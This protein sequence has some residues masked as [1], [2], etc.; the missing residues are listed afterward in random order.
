[1]TEMKRTVGFFTLGCK[2][3]Q[4]ESEAI[5]ELFEARGYT[6]LPSEDV[7]DVYI[8][9]TCTVTAES[10]RK[11][12][13]II[14]R[15]ITR[16]PDAFIL[17]TG[18]LA[19][20]TPESI[21][22]IPGVDYVCGNADKTGIVDAADRLMTTKEKNCMAD[23]RVLPLD[24]MP[25]EPMKIQKFDRTRAYIK[26]EDGCESH[27]TYCIIPAARG[28]IRSKPPAEVLAEVKSLTEGGCREIV[29]TG[30]ETA[31]YGKD[32]A[33]VTLADLLEEV[34]RIPGIGRIRL[35]SLDPSLMKPP[36]V[37]R[38]S[39]LSS[40]APHFHLSMQSGSD[41][42]LRRMKRKYNSTMALENI[43]ELRRVIPNLMLTT[44]MIVGFPGE[45]EEDFEQTMEFA[46]QAEFLMIHVFPYSGRRGTPAVSMSG[47]ISS[48]VKHERALRL[49]NLEAEI[50]RRI[51]EK[52]IAGQTVT[53]VLFETYENGY[54]CGHTAN[55]IEVR[56]K[57]DRNRRSELCPVRFL[58]TD[59]NT[60][61]AELL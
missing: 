50:R 8:I 12:R 32:L 19:Q 59:G 42:V 34:D 10:D 36:F 39:R 54:A 44:D 17:V 61:T 20:T 53:D 43:Q 40:L 51:L 23:V 28:A 7:C 29:L 27:C 14:R 21:A 6:V 41:A 56:V 13:Q 11:A 1:M 57:S 35:G 26:I 55:F 2:V 38:I 30:I 24:G 49:S 22:C 47:Q 15:A 25:F 31:S 48:A 58:E 45:T 3:N 5:G 18:C 33:G 37:A 9:N 16:N 60:I 52:E 46:R 4:Y